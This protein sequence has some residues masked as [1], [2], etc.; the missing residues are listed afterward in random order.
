[1]GMPSSMLSP[2][3]HP[4][5]MLTLR[6]LLPSGHCQQRR[7]VT[8]HHCCLFPFLN[9]EWAPAPKKLIPTT[10]SSM[11]SL[12]CIDP[13]DS[14][15]HG[16]IVCAW[17]WQTKQL[18]SAPWSCV[19]WLF[20]LDAPLCLQSGRS[21]AL[22]LSLP[23]WFAVCSYLTTLYTSFDNK[24]PY[25]FAKHTSDTNLDE[26]SKH[27]WPLVVSWGVVCKFSI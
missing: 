9:H 23:R 25:K 15:T 13:S 4:A 11:G 26:V 1:M 22:L 10:T 3:I 6:P 8:Q 24:G 18:S 17:M 7:L 19:K 5:K 21:V 14:M 27:P 12:C 16:C 2:S 20:L